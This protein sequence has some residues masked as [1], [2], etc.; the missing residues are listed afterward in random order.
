MRNL[1]TG[2]GALAGSVLGLAVS[3]G[4]GGSS[5]GGGLPT[6]GPTIAAAATTW[7]WIDVPES[8][9]NDGS[10]TGFAVNPQSANA[11]DATSLLIYFEGGGACWDYTTCYVLNSATMGPITAAEWPTHEAALPPLLDR[12]RTTNPFRNA[13]MVYI[14][15]CTG[16]LHAGDNVATY[17]SGTTTQTYHHKGRPDT[18]AFLTRVAST[19]KSVS[20]VVVSGSSAGG[21]GALLTYDLMRKTY[22]GAHMDLIDDAGTLLEGDAVPPGER[23]AWFAS[24]NIGDLVDSL[25]TGCRDDFSLLYPQIAARYTRDRMALLSSLQDGT[26]STYFLLSGADFQTD[27]LKMVDERLTP[28]SNFRAFLIAGSQ[29]PVLTTP[30]VTTQGK[31]LESWLIDMVSDQPGWDTVQP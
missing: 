31:S 5:P 24:W 12:T 11:Q 27:L 26:I 7:T 25:C 28:T 17:S 13:T 14:P 6:N 15:Y 18:V 21:Y 20:S 29:H 10:A 23:T 9:C 3:C 4:G 30:D 19:W 22:T 1:T 16:D 8:V 2:L